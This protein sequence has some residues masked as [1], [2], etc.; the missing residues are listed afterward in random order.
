MSSYRGFKQS[1]TPTGA[2]TGTA[3]IHS[4][5]FNIDSLEGAAFEPVWTGTPTGTFIVEVSLSYVPNPSDTNGASPLPPLNAG[6]W[7]NLGATIAENPAG[8]TGNTYIPILASCAGWI[9][10]TYT[11]ASGSGVLSGTFKGKTRG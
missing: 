3:T 8:S 1:I 2:M 4:Q 5:P 10:L 7:N 9:R 6:F 11:N